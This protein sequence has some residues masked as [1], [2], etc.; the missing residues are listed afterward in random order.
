MLTRW[1]HIACNVAGVLLLLPAGWFAV[2]QNWAA[3]TFW[4]FAAWLPVWVAKDVGHEFHV[5]IEK[6]AWEEGDC[7]VGE[8]I[9][10]D[11]DGEAWKRGR[12]D[13][14]D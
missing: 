8:V 10:D 6:T 5:W 1:F 4:L 12:R 9:D 14:G 13:D 2:E 11:D 7:E 3:A